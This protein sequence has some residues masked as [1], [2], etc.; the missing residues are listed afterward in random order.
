MANLVVGVGELRI[1]SVAWR[2]A[3]ISG[4]VHTD[5][6]S[7]GIASEV[8]LLMCAFGFDRLRL[9]RI[10]GTCDPRNRASAAVLRKIGMTH[11]GTMRRTVEIR[12]G[13]R[14]SELHSLIRPE[15]MSPLTGADM[16][17]RVRVGA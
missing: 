16:D 9:E 4:M 5:W 1:T 7:R 12:T 14:D 17:A 10:E 11:E 6:W 2:R 15:W 3:D 13:W 8:A